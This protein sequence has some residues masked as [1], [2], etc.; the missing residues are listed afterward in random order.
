MLD[1]IETR[2]SLHKIPET[3]FDLPKTV[4][5]VKNA[6]NGLSCKVFEPCR[7]AVCAFFDMG[8]RE[9]IA[10]RADMDA[11]DVCERTGAAY[12]STHAGKMHACG[13]DGHTA[14]LLGLAHG[15]DAMENKPP[16]NV[17][18]VFQ[19]AEESGG[20]AQFVCESGVFEDYAVKCVF[21]LHLWP[22]LPLGGV[23]SRPGALM[24]CA[25]EVDIIMQGK[26]AHVAKSSE[27]ADALCAL[28]RTLSGCYEMEKTE[29]SPEIPRLLKFGL[30]NAGTV[31]NAIAAGGVLQGTVRA[32]DGDTFNYMKKRVEEIALAAAK[33]TGCTASVQFS[34]G[35]PALIND[36]E[37]F[38]KAAKALGEGAI[39]VMEKPEMTAED[40]SFYGQRIPSV[41]LLIG[42]G[43]EIALHA[44]NYN[45]N[46]EA[47]FSGLDVL[48]KLLW[49]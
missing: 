9:T 19:P 25:S 22:F 37:L 6:L 44:E 1:I 8:E 10:F 11:L 5:F 26:S 31:R 43:V 17:L 21:G 28:A 15:I 39:T 42:T 35:Y 32:I 33:D 3:G 47:L 46:E 27:G 38:E 24:A 48:K 4:A 41:F 40:F 2:R 45:I 29:I 18:L 16:H 14:M 12:A 34:C 7:S 30:L 13:H 20:G 23:F 36:T 49:I